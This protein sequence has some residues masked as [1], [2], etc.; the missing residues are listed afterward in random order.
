MI[1]PEQWLDK[2]KQ[3]SVGMR[4]R[5]WHLAERRPNLV[6]GND[7]DKWWCYC[8]ACHD[9]GIVEKAH[10][11]LGGDT[12]PADNDCTLPCD[13]MAIQHTEFEVPI[14][15]FLADKNMAFPYLPPLFYSKSRSR[16]LVHVQGGWHG[17]DLTGKSL[18]KWMNYNKAHYVGHVGR[19]TVVVED[20]FS[21]FK[22]K[23]A[24]R[25][26]PAIRVMCA[27]GTAA[28][29]QMFAAFA[30]APPE[31]LVWMF[32]ADTA[33]DSGALACMTR[34]RPYGIKVNRRARPPEGLDPKDLTCEQIRNL[35]YRGETWN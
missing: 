28:K 25:N 23:W 1:H 21:Y 22:V 4:T 2:A 8:H 32:D 19:C 35:I 27:L 33:G 7:L 9:G 6:I 34:A 11:I 14:A 17:R 15:R 18:R 24:V 13:I 30:T 16:L 26:M 3:L 20:L 10:V 29:D 5:V 31:E 12:A